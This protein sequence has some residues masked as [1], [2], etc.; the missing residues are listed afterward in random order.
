MFTEPLIASVPLTLVFLYF[1]W[2]SV[3]GWIMETIYCSVL[4]KRLVDRG[5]LYGPV[6]PIYGVGALLMV[7]LLSRFTGYPVLF[8]IISI[9]VMS[10]WEYLVGW[11]LETTTHIKYWDYSNQRFNIKGRVCLKNSMYW[12]LVSYIAIYGIHPAT[13][14]LFDNLTQNLRLGLSFA[15]AA[16]MLTDT[17]LTIRSLALTTAFLGKAEA[18]RLEIEERRT[19]LRQRLEEAAVQAALLRLEL[20]HKDMLAE[21]AHY[22]KRLRSVYRG[23]KSTRF[24]SP[25]RRIRKNG[26]A[27]KNH[28]IQRLKQL[29]EKKSNV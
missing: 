28:R 2:Y 13:V 17:T 15:A 11:A 10:S 4:Q 24:K 21:A 8:G 25:L 3:L 27:L 29:K 16:V 19:E 5:F 18:V 6:C 22:S 23:M 20:E 12:G 26:E 7:L 9:I 1:I 14:H